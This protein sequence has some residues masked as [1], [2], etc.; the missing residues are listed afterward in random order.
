MQGGIGLG[1][2]AADWVIKQKKCLEL[3][4]NP[5]DEMFGPSAGAAV[6]TIA[7]L[8]AIIMHCPEGGRVYFHIWFDDECNC[9]SNYVIICDKCTGA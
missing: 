8:A 3:A 2:A 7:N 9:K 1:V 6:L 5:G 4:E